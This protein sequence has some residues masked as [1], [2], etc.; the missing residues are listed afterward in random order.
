MQTCALCN[1]A[2]LS[3]QNILRYLFKSFSSSNCVD[4]EGRK[5]CSSL[6]ND[7]VL[8]CLALLVSNYRLANFYKT[9]V[10]D[11]STSAAST[12]KR[13]IQRFNFDL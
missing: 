3:R 7:L 1:Q 12:K 9:Q 8:K 5:K 4:L 2:E 10:S 11:P 6:P 13:G